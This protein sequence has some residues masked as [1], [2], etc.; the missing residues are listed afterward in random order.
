MLVCVNDTVYT[1]GLLC[2]H[3]NIFVCTP[4]DQEK[5]HKTISLSLPYD[6]NCHWNK[7]ETIGNAKDRVKLAI[8]K[9]IMLYLHRLLSKNF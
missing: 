1:V 7:I 6:T 4:A 3:A 8:V 9:P 2:I 5:F